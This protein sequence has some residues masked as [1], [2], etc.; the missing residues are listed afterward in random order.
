MAVSVAF[1]VPSLVHSNELHTAISVIFSVPSSV[2]SNEFHPAVSVTFSVP[3]SVQW[4]EEGTLNA[5]ETAVCN[6][7]EYLLVF[8]MLIFP[9]IMHKNARKYWARDHMAYTNVMV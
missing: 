9:P 1:S 4:T 6:S 7:F 5:T 3:S 8:Q 2:H